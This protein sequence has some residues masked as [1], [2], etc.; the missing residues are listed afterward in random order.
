MDEVHSI[1][2]LGFPMSYV[3]F[4]LL[5]III[6]IT[7]GAVVGIIGF[8]I[9]YGMIHLGM[10]RIS[11][12]ID[13][14]TQLIEKFLPNSLIKVKENIQ[15]SFIIKDLRSEKEK[16]VKKNQVFLFHPHGAFSSSYYFH[17]VSHL[18]NWPIQK[19]NSYSTISRYLFW[20]PF[21][22]ELGEKYR[23]V[24]NTYVSMKNTLEKGYTLNLIPGGTS[25]IPLTQ[26]GKVIVSLLKRKGIFKMALE[27]GSPLV[28]VVSYGE[29]E[30]Y[31][32]VFPNLQKWIQENFHISIPIPTLT[33]SLTWLNLIEEP[34][35][36]PVITV[37]G[38]PIEVQK[39][40]N[41][42]EEDIDNLKKNYI[43]KL[44]ELYKQTKP[45]NYAEEIEFV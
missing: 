20:L 28:P 10:I 22:D 23:I 37:I 36:D 43:Q 45:D 9:V 21:A 31:N 34:F 16:E 8:L 18:T 29:N 27:T 3:V 32:L 33:S 11:P 40:E 30:I 7:V 19:Q 39:K 38:N 12:L 44:K 42:S 15:K 35:R 2:Q 14:I 6:L 25:E 1:L 17:V 41:P 24:P 5:I 4:W 13:K 26:K